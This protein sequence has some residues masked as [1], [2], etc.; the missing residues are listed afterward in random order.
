MLTIRMNE[1]AAA[2][3]QPLRLTAALSA[4]DLHDELRAKLSQGVVESE[5]ALIFAAHHRSDSPTAAIA[6]MGWP[7]LT[8]YECQVNSFHLEDYAP[9]EVAVLEDG[10][11]Q[12]NHADQVGLLRLGLSVADAVRS[13]VRAHTSRTAIRC[14]ISANDTNGVFRFHRIRCGEQW[15][16]H[17]LDQYRSEM[18][19]TVDDQP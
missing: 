19:V 13:L 8:H 5:G 6:R 3:L 7:D 2:A 10:Q 17:D 4:A 9:V 11:P 15:G 14:I 1:S 12:I 16:V 18:A